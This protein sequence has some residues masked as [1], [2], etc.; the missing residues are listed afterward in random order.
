M[1][2]KSS[3]ELTEKIFFV[4][5]DR[6]ND[7]IPYYVGKGV[8][9][10]V[11]MPY[12]NGKHKYVSIQHGFNRSIEYETSDEFAAF[13]REQTLIKEYHTFVQDPEATSLACNYTLGGDGV[14]GLKWSSDSIEKVKI[15]WKG[16]N[17]RRG[18]KLPP[19]TRQKMSENKLGEKNPNF[20]KTP[21]NKG[22]KCSEQTR[23][24]LRAKMLG[25]KIICKNCKQAGHFARA[26]KENQQSVH[27]SPKD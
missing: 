2:S 5:V 21:W 26:C 6:T 9:R 19:E 18:V 8:L 17:N 12:R 11:R 23:A 1:D 22:I 7:G 4:Y 3:Q 15:Q 14:S 10:R 27:P 20:G 13:D 16:R 24:K 25:R